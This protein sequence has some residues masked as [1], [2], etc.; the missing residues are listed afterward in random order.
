[1]HKTGTLIALIGC[2]CILGCPAVSSNTSIVGTWWTS[3]QDGD[4]TWSAEWTFSKDGSFLT[5]SSTSSS[6]LVV[7]DAKGT[8]NTDTSKNPHLID[9]TLTHYRAG[10]S[11]WT[12]YDQPVVMQGIYELVESNTLRLDFGNGPGAIRPS[13]FTENA[14]AFQRQ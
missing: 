3:Q 9:L 11:E 7:V 5:D 12:A 13:E 14:R 8:Y 10:D 4:E 2:V 6:T 1:M